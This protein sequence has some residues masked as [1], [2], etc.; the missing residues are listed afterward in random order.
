MGLKSKFVILS[1]PISSSLT[2]NRDGETRTASLTDSMGYRYD[3]E[4]SVVSL[5]V[6]RSEMVLAKRLPTALPLHAIAGKTSYNAEV[7][8]LI[9]NSPSEHCI[10]AHRLILIA[11]GVPGE[12]NLP[13]NANTTYGIVKLE[14]K[15]FA[16]VVFL[17]ND[18]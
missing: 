2:C 3:E 1:E 9:N 8:C 4:L 16:A 6:V 17:D 14:V 11:S 12:D 7:S 15:V 18:T 13:S 10:I 5:T